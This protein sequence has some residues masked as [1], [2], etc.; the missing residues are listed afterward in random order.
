MD[1]DILA[2]ATVMDSPPTRSTLRYIS[3]IAR[4]SQIVKPNTTISLPKMGTSVSCSRG[5]ESQHSADDFTVIIIKAVI[6]NCSP[7][8]G[9]KYLYSSSIGVST[10]NEPYL[11]I[12]TMDPSIFTMPTVMLCPPIRAT[13]RYIF[14]IAITLYIV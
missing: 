9:V 3:F 12:S 14:F 8:P 1:P 10:S 6:T 2:V 5:V 11:C 13:T 7:L 4:A